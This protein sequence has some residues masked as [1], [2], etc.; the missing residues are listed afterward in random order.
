MSC[1]QNLPSPDWTAKETTKELEDLG[2]KWKC[3]MSENIRVLKMEVSDV[4]KYLR[5]ENTNVRCLKISE[6]WKWKCQMFENIWGLKIKCQLFKKIWCLK[7]E[8][9]DV[10]NYLM[11]ENENVSGKRSSVFL[12]HFHVSR[13]IRRKIS[14]ACTWHLSL[15]YVL[16]KKNNHLQNLC[17]CLNNLSH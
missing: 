6:F 9:S 12:R 4:S 8:K 14:L 2:F 7:I 1:Q 15:L 10:C 17:R 11:F 13:D 5:F 16:T 3:Q